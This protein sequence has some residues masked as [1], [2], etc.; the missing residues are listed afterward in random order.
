MPICKQNAYKWITSLAVSAAIAA[1]PAASAGDL[2]RLVEKDGR[3][4]LMVDGAPYLM[5][6]VQANNSSNYPS[7]LPLVWPALKAAHANTLE[8]PIAWEQV[9]PVEGKFDFSFVDELLKQ[10][11]ANDVKLVLLWFGTW[12]NNNPDYAPEWV[13]LD[14]K[15]F[16]RVINAKGEVKN[17]LSPHF[18]STLEADKRAFVALMQHLKVAC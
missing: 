7:Q 8:M 16:P 2:P 4:A 10:A 17:S 14:N 6:G 3:H 13:K 18:R 11:R 5:L 9:E 12:K 15:R 1:S